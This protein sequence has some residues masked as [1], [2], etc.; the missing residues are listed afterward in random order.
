MVGL[1]QSKKRKISITIKEINA[2]KI[3]DIIRISHG[4]E[5]VSSIIDASL[6][7]SLSEISAL[8]NMQQKNKIDLEEELL[9]KRLRELKE[10]KR[11]VNKK[12]EENKSS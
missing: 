9:E 8:I 10:I 2:K 6:D 5:T 7:S 4:Q 12:E 11:I 3:E 1:T